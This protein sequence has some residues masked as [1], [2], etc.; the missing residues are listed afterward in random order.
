MGKL[1]SRFCHLS[2]NVTCGTPLSSSFFKP[3]EMTMG[4]PISIF[5]SLLSS[6]PPL[7]SPIA[8]PNETDLA[9]VLHKL[10][11]HHSYSYIFLY[12]S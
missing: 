1:L 11:Q 4:N 9:L 10:I 5:A 8:K 3:D 6:L 12:M 2:N 7:S